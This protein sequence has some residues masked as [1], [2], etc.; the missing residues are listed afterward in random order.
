MSTITNLPYIFGT[1]FL[2]IMIAAGLAL[3]WIAEIS[4]AAPL[5]ARHAGV[6]SP[7]A[8]L[9]ALLFGLFSAFLA[10][11]V[12]IH[13]ERARASIAREAAATHVILNIA[14]ALGERGRPL[15][16]LVAAFGNLSAGDDWS[17]APQQA[18]AEA[19]SL[20]M[21]REVLFGGLATADAEVR[22][23]AVASIMDIRAARRDRNSVEHS[24]TGEL[25]W[26]AALV[27]GLL[28]QIGVVVVHLGKPR[29]SA[30]AVTLF[31]VGMA[32]MLWVILERL[33][34]FGGAYPVTL[35]PIK[36]AYQQSR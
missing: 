3:V 5:L 24:R 31:A 19:Q 7:F 27:L 22:H 11:D 2:V 28:T 20:R 13:A 12:F 17:S 33:D 25:K 30:L 6:V 15:H 29:A 1:L 16:D 21:M 8:G 14:D 34:P 36:A 10:N 4:P 23:T 18:A 26:A 35:E 32:F 9:L